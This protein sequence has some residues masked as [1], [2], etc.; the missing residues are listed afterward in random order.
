MYGIWLVASHVE[1][2]GFMR[3][4]ES[5]AAPHRVI[6]AQAGIQ[7]HPQRAD[8]PAAQCATTHA[9]VRSG[10]PPSRNDTG[11]ETHAEN[12]LIASHSDHGDGLLMR[13]HATR[14]AG[15]GE[16]G[17]AYPARRQRSLQYFTCSQSF[18]HLRRQLNGRWQTGQILLG[19]SAL[20]RRRGMERLSGGG[21][22]GR[23]RSGCGW[24]RS[25]RFPPQ[26]PARAGRPP[27]RGRCRAP[28]LPQ[29]SGCRR[30]V[31]SPIFRPGA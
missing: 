9:V 8:H 22:C 5:L 25:F 1:T 29:T 10:F 2:R 26:R 11:G 30:R 16:R 28:G 3:Y 6:P 31:Q 13:G 27:G 4:E 7:V 24:I 15:F 20:A 19:K 21:G 18:A 17:S 14:P 12:G 23:R